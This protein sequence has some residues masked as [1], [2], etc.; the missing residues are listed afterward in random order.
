MKDIEKRQ[1]SD[2]EGFR[3]PRLQRIAEQMIKTRENH[4]KSYRLY[5]VLSEKAKQV[6]LDESA[7]GLDRDLARRIVETGVDGMYR[8]PRPNDRW[9]ED[10]AKAYDQFL[11]RK[12]MTKEDF[13]ELRRETALRLQECRNSLQM[14]RGLIAQLN[15]SAPDS[16]SSDVISELIINEQL[17]EEYGDLIR[18]IDT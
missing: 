2:W 17:V 13:A 15:A 8:N 14:L 12:S 10:P 7:N 11:A 18:A 5:L 3:D 16:I 4:D 1:S 9:V 6:V